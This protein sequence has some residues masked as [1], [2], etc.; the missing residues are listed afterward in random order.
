MMLSSSTI[1][2][3]FTKFQT[4]DF[5]IKCFE[6]ILLSILFMK[7]QNIPSIVHIDYQKKTGVIFE[8][9]KIQM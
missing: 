8:I 7:M 5:A 4:L 2:I 1:G 3:I 6:N 9:M